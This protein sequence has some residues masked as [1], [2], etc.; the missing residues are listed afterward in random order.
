MRVEVMTMAII[1]VELYGEIVEMNDDHFLKQWHNRM[2]GASHIAHML[3]AGHA[4]GQ[5]DVSGGVK[6]HIWPATG[7]EKG[8]FDAIADEELAGLVQEMRQS[9]KT[10]SV[11]HETMITK[12]AAFLG[13]AALESERDRYNLYDKLEKAY[14]AA[15]TTGRHPSWLADHEYRQMT[16]QMMGIV[17]RM[18]EITTRFGNRVLALSDTIKREDL[19]DIGGDMSRSPALPPLWSFQRQGAIRAEERLGTD[20]ED[21]VAPEQRIDGIV[22]LVSEGM[23]EPEKAIAWLQEVLKLADSDA[24]KVKVY[25]ALARQHEAAGDSREAISAYS[26]ALANGE[27]LSLAYFWRGRQYFIKNDLQAARRDLEQALALGLDPHLGTEATDYLQR[28]KGS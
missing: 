2:R 21:E 28:I 5:P 19:F 20:A 16:I 10:L 27:P 8:L 22:D 26:D 12:L 23:L 13:I 9:V 4:H 7:E 11:L 24:L 14:V 15:T 18:R 17:I 3:Y 25:T 1:R 6:A